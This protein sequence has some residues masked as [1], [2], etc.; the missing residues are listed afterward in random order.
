MGIDIT[1]IINKHYQIESRAYKILLSHSQQVTQKALQIAQKYTP[2]PD[3]QFIEEASMLHDIGIILTQAPD[4]D[5][6]GKQPY[7]CHGYL[8][9]ELLEKEK[10]FQHALVCERHIGMGI[11]AKEIEEQ[12]LPLPK[13]D[14]IPISIEEKIICL[15]DKFFSKNPTRSGQELSIEN[16][17]QSLAKFGTHKVTAFQ[18][19]LNQFMPVK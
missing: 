7:I 14:M 18:Q 6:H 2:L 12:N 13:R 9:R 16:I 8:G 1:S 17:N 5:C 3:L 19:L 11:T 4:I 15:A 10:L